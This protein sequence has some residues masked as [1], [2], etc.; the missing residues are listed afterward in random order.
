MTTPEQEPGSEP[1][2]SEEASSLAVPIGLLIVAILC[3][4]ASLAL[5]VFGVWPA[6]ILLVACAGMA[7]ISVHKIRKHDASHH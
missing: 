2:A 3:G 4:A 1:R 7:S 5:V 6:V